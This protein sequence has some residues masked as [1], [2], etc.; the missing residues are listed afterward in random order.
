MTKLK[1]AYWKAVSLLE[2]SGVKEARAEALE[3]LSA[4]AG[5]PLDPLTVRFSD[6][7]VDMEAVMDFIRPRLGG[8]PLAYV[9]HS[10]WFY[11]RAFY[12]DSR[13][14]IPRYDTEVVCEKALRLSEEKRCQNVL[15]LCCGSGCIGITLALEGN[16]GNILLA[17]ID[18]GALAVAGT[19]IKRLGVQQTCKCLRSNLLE[20][21]RGS[22]D[23][24]V[25]NPPYISE[26]D[27]ICLDDEVRCYEPQTALLAEEDGYA[28]YQRIVKDA[29]NCL[30]P[31]GAL[32]LEIG[33]T[34]ADKIETMLAN[35]GY[36]HI[37]READVAGR[38]RVLSAQI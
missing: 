37:E 9:L 6:R 34:Q 16:Y 22:W 1:D 24:I 29:K 38:P 33:D 25:S 11:G 32:V 12:V 23:L 10:K 3:I 5:A 7:H 2:S 35:A 14:L 31:G 18:E 26:R 8:Q 27:Y 30:A 4:A 28:F 20:D 19:N 36:T 21:V 17:D 15:D 13:V